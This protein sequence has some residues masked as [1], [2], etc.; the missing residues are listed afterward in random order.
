MRGPAASCRRPLA[1]GVRGGWRG[2]RSTGQGNGAITAVVAMQARLVVRCPSCAFESPE[3]ARFCAQCGD[4]LAPGCPAC[5]AEASPTDKFCAACGTPLPAAAYAGTPA[6]AGRS[7]AARGRLPA[8]ERRQVTVL[9]ADLVG[10]TRLASELDAEE[11]HRLLGGFFARADRIVE[12]FGGSIDKHIGDCVMAVFGAPLA[13]DNDPERAVRAA[14]AIRDALPELGRELGRTVGVHI[15]IASG[16]VVASDTG[17]DARRDY[18]VTGDTVNLAS[19][20]TDRAGADEILISDVVRGR[21]PDGFA[22]T[23][24]GALEVEGLAAPVTAWRLLGLAEAG[25]APARPFVGRRAELAQFRGV[26]EACR[27]GG[28]GQAVYLRG[29]AGI[30]K[31]RITEEFRRAAEARGFACHTGLVLDFGTGAGQDAIGALVRGLL[32]VQGA[33]DL[34]TRSAAAARALAEGLVEDEHGVFLHD[35]LDL[36]LPLGLRALYDAMDH[37]QRQRGRRATVARLVERSSARRPRLL[38]IED[39][40][41][42]DRQ[43]LEQLACLAQTVASAPALLVMTSRVEG[44]PLDQAW[45]ATTAGAPLLTIDLGPLRPNEAEELAGA[46]LEASGEFARRC[47]ERAGGHPLFLE[48]LLRHAEERAELGVPGTVQSLVQ[49]RMD[50]LEPADRQALLA[51]SVF[52][53]RFSLPALRDLL[54]HADYGGERLV[55]QLLVRPEGD[56]LLFAHALIRDAVYDTLLKATRRTLH[57]RAAA[58]FEGRDPV[59]YAEHLDRAEDPAAAAAYL[60]AARREA[61][62]YH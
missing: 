17:S 10:Y 9:F 53:Q 22:C 58:W 24:I 43:T 13:H 21:L 12:A 5:G 60:A 55:E 2:H 14:L 40:H 54:E 26:L 16:Q 30:G 48:Q 23:G 32:D 42:A 27:D 52:G 61:A 59:L 41:W 25:A 28:A 47:L 34:A 29:S 1:L 3:G 19:R 38:L 35:L 20:L 31:T 62:A 36:P 6:A 51:A 18:T 49:A 39:V 46:Y 33:G 8:G 37:Q 57:R 56:D 11:V 15:G 44:D 45:R 7:A 4:R 50:Q